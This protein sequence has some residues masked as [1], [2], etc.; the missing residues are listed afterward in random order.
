MTSTSSPAGQDTSLAEAFKRCLEE[1]STSSELWEVLQEHFSTCP[2][3]FW[4]LLAGHP[5]C[6]SAGQ[7]EKGEM[8]TM[9]I[10]HRIPEH[11]H[12]M[13]QFPVF[14]EDCAN[15]KGP[16]KVLR[17]LESSRDDSPD[18][19]DSDS[20]LDSYG[21]NVKRAFGP[22]GKCLPGAYQAIRGVT[23]TSGSSETKRTKHKTQKRKRA[24]Q[25]SDSDY[26]DNKY[27]HDDCYEVQRRPQ[28]APKDSTRASSESSA[29]P[30]RALIPYPAPP[31]QLAKDDA[32]PRNSREWS[33]REEDCAIKHMLYVSKYTQ[34]C[35]E[36]R[37]G[38]A[39]RRLNEELGSH[40]TQTSFKNFWNRTGRARSKFDERKN[41]SAP[42]ATSQ[43]GK[44]VKA[45]RKMAQKQR[46][47]VLNTDNKSTTRSPNFSSSRT[48]GSSSNTPSR[49]PSKATDKHSRRRG[50]SIARDT[51]S[52]TSSKPSAST[53]TAS[54]GD[55]SLNSKPESIQKMD[56]SSKDGDICKET[57]GLAPSRQSSA[58]Q[59]RLYD[60]AARVNRKRKADDD[61]YIEDSASTSQRDEKRH[62]TTKERDFGFMRNGVAHDVDGNPMYQVSKEDEAAIMNA[63][64]DSGFRQRKRVK[65]GH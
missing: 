46:D 4:N 26:D 30:E 64:N 39:A 8:F 12:R 21:V 35:G 22:S 28:Q 53:S 24:I 58:S 54:Q 47:A 18:S 3:A 37:F 29:T 13:V 59:S 6:V 45:R 42:L 32:R 40:R 38:D 25:E 23:N 2:A 9:G 65:Y 31:D 10:L 49:T 33:L 34:I 5:A 15:Q 52:A 20:Q 51:V 1:A 57:R 19:P 43:Q 61:E 14:E 7:V 27:Q 60:T 62:A 55:D 11:E 36:A 56:S 48:P 16:I 63:L 41:K 44:D 17:S 50:E